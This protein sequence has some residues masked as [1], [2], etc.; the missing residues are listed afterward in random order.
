M[1]PSTSTPNDNDL[2]GKDD[3]ST[4]IIM[5]LDI[6]IWCWLQYFYYIPGKYCK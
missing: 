2:I 1:Q 4:L 5:M 6:L 3:Y